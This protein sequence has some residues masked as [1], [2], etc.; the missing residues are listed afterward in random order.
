M[1]HSNGY[2]SGEAFVDFTSE[3]EAKAAYSSMLGY[4]IEN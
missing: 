2:F 1:S 3:I 4:Q